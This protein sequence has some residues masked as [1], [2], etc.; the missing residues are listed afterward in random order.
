[1]ND[2]E[3]D[4]ALSVGTILT[5]LP[6]PVLPHCKHFISSQTIA[7]TGN[8]SFLSSGVYDA[9]RSF[10][11]LLSSVVCESA[12]CAR[13]PRV[14]ATPTTTIVMKVTRIKS[15]WRPAD[16][17]FSYV[18]NAV[19]DPR[20]SQIQNRMAHTL[21]SWSLYGRKR[22]CSMKDQTMMEIWQTNRFS[23]YMTIDPTRINVR[24][25]AFQISNPSISSL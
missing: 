9:N 20:I 16:G 18:L 3:S 4:S 1:M 21:L 8:S 7:K 24:L 2:V 19:M 14:I 17:A 5:L 13:I 11:V 23:G 12:T 15:I 25:M 22:T 6:L 10:V